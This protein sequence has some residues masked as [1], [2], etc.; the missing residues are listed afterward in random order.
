MISR[1]QNASHTSTV[2]RMHE[3]Y[4]EI[5]SRLGAASLQGPRSPLKR[6]AEALWSQATV[7]RGQS[8][9]RRA[10]VDTRLELLRVVAKG[11]SGERDKPYVVVADE[12]CGRCC[13]S[14]EESDSDSDSSG[15]SDD[16]LAT[17]RIRGRALHDERVRVVGKASSDEKMATS[18]EVRGLDAIGLEMA[19]LPTMAWGLELT[20]LED[21]M[22]SLLLSEL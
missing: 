14:S 9:P 4:T 1:H 6:R 19:S 2:A 15:Q 22:E 3:R 5:E 18:S 13:G 20:G 8:S 11:L 7:S 12:G 21:A 10:D 16:E 17:P